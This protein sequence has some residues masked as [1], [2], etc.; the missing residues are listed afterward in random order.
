MDALEW[1]KRAVDLGAGEL[2]VTSIDRD[3]T[4]Q[5]YDLGLTRSISDAVPVPVI[6]AGGAG[7]MD[8][9][10]EVIAEGRA[11]AVCVASL[12]HYRFV[13]ECRYDPGEFTGE[14]NVEY[15]H[16]G[17]RFSKIEDASLPEL[18]SWLAGRGMACRLAGKGVSS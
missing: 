4:G 6:A 16:Q 14:G 17:A 7:K 8:H 2:A 11:D 15:L 18:K 5:G 13:R 3:G 1:A 9:V 10:R 12:L